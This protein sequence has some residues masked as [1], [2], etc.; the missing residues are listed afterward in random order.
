MMITD[1]AIAFSRRDES[2]AARR[3]HKR[4][5]LRQ[6]II[7]AAILAAVLAATTYLLEPRF[8]DEYVLYFQVAEVAVVGFFIIQILGSVSYSLALVHSE[9]TAKSMKSLVRIAGA[10]VVIAFITSYL[11]RDPVIAASISTIAGLVMGFS[12]MNI[13]SNVIA[14]MYLAIT[15][16][17]RIDD[18]I[19]V[20]GEVGVAQNIGML[21]TRLAPENGDEMLATNSSL[22]TTSIVLKKEI[23]E[24]ETVRKDA[25]AA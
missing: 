5:A 20:F 25:E 14:G 11:S 24:S 17:F 2:P 7:L 16:P 6:I 9:Q 12:S 23:E 3:A 13:L 10:I 19:K 22:V 18:K 4:K 15:R 8:P 1:I 21:Y